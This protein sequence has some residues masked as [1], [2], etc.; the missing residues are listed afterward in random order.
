MARTPGLLHV[1]A[2]AG[3]RNA[4]TDTTKPATHAEAEALAIKAVQ[5]YLNACR[6]TEDQ[7]VANYLMKLISVAGILMSRSVGAAEAFERL[8]G[9]AYFVAENGSVKP[10]KLVRL[11]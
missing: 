7:Q 1:L 8:H 9:T 11:Q 6:M 3:E 5:D 10:Q 4:M 2:K